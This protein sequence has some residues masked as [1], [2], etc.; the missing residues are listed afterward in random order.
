MYSFDQNPYWDHIAHYGI[1]GQKWGIRRYQNKDGSLTTAGIRRYGVEN[2]RTLKSGTKIQNI[3]RDDLSSTSNSYKSK[4]LYSSYTDYDKTGYVDL[5]GNWQYGGKGMKNT[6]L[7]KKDIKIASERDVVKTLA[8]MYRDNPDRVTQLMSDA[9]RAQN[10]TFFGGSKRS[11]NRHMKKLV[12]NVDSNRSLEIGR[13]FL[14]DVPITGK[15]SDL[16]NDFYA[17]MVKKGFD[18]VLDPNDA[19]QGAGAQDPLIIFNMDKLGKEGSVPL[20]YDELQSAY[21]YTYTHEWQRSKKDS[22]KMAHG[23]LNDDFVNDFIMHYCVKGIKWG[24]RKVI[25]DAIDEHEK[26]LNL[27]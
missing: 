16:A 9:Y 18:A 25:N 10:L 17:R 15:A 26:L 24:V 12:K 20:T 8:E 1:K 6:F 13:Q 14:H 19:Y 3:S 22:S 4:R 2:S 23:V 11:I 5:M 21:E 7:V 27:E